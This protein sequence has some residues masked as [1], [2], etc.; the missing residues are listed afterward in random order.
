MMSLKPA[1]CGL[2]RWTVARHDVLRLGSDRIDLTNPGFTLRG[3]EEVTVDASTSSIAPDPT[4]RRPIGRQRSFATDE[5]GRRTVGTDSGWQLVSSRPDG[6][7]TLHTLQSGSGTIEVLNTNRYQNVLNRFDVN[8]NGI[9]E[10]LDALLGLNQLSRNASG[11]PAG[12]LTSPPS[13]THAYMDV[14]GDGG[15]TPIDIL[16][17]INHLTVQRAH[18]GEG[19]TNRSD[20]SPASRLSTEPT[21][22]VEEFGTQFATLDQPFVSMTPVPGATFEIEELGSPAAEESDELLVGDIDDVI[23]LLALD[24]L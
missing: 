6:D 1:R 7:P 21:T 3:V 18:A 20:T 14:N 9:I 10:P 11:S 4:I 24:R 22:I 19:P 16:M 13:A 5:P 15:L 23:S 2:R 17:V 8:G 12:E